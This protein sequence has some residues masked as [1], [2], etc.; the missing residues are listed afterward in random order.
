[1]LDVLGPIWR[2]F[3]YQ[4]GK[5]L[6]SFLYAN[7]DCIA[8]DPRFKCTG[9]VLTKLRTISA[10][11]I[12]RLLKKVKSRLKIKGTS[13]TKG[14]KG[15]IKSQ[16]P[17]MSHFECKEQG[18]GIWQTDLVQHDGGNASG[19]YP[20]SWQRQRVYQQ[21]SLVNATTS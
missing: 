20:A 6:A 9:E 10:A 7:I 15:H 17:V 12:D 2:A 5:L 11:T 21:R 4:C 1:M 19:A 3:N 13:D 16:I 14:A 18:P 8:A